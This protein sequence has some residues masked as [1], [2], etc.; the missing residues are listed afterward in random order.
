M[1]AGSSP[2]GIEVAKTGLVNEIRP[3][4]YIFKDFMLTQE[5]AAALDEIAVRFF[6]TV[7]SCNHPEYAVID[8]G[9]KC[10]P[11]DAPPG[12]APYYYPGY[13][14]V[15]GNPNLRLTRMNEEHGMITAQNGETGLAVGQVISL[16]P[17]H[18]CTAV[19]MQSWVYLLENGVL[20]RQKVD[21]RGMLI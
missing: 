13:G 11:T 7:V 9:T 19:N 1:S 15:E 5:G 21:A 16:I 3:G 20:T 18:V 6:A 14:V 8:G 10:F 12:L 4:T 17:I 2:T